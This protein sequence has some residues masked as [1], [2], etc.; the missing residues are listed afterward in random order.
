MNVRRGPSFLVPDS[1]PHRANIVSD[2]LAREVN[3]GRI[4]LGLHDANWTA[5]RP[6]AKGNPRMSALILNRWKFGRIQ[7]LFARSSKPK[8][9]PTLVT[10]E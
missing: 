4:G 8:A 2:Y 6:L 3:P 9:S 5:K 10:D 7:L 1:L